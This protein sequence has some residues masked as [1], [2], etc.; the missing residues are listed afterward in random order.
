[1]ANE[2]AIIVNASLLLVQNILIAAPTF[3]G[4]Q[5]FLAISIIVLAIAAHLAGPTSDNV[6]DALPYTLFWPVWLATLEKCITAGKRNIEDFYWRVDR[7]AREGT[8]MLAFGPMKFLW[9]AAMMFNA[10]LVRWNLQVKN[11][12]P[13]TRLRKLNFLAAR[14]LQLVK[15]VLV[16]DLVFQLAIR[17]FWTR[18]DGSVHPDSK[19]LTIRNESWG[20]S[21]LNALVFGCGPYFSMNLQYVVAAIFSVSFNL[22]QP[23][24]WPPLYGRITDATTVRAFWGQFWHQTIRRPLT[25]FA[26]CIT[27]WM[28]FERSTDLTFY[29][30]IWAAF[31]ISGI[32]HAQ[33]L[34]LLPRAFNITLYEA[35][36]GMFYFF[37]WQALAITVEDLIQRAWQKTGH[38]FE[39]LGRM[40][41]V[42]GYMWV[43]CSLWISLPW[44]AD[45]YIRL[46]ITEEPMLSF[47]V[48][49]P[50]VRIRPT[51]QAA[52]DHPA[53][54]S[55]H[56]GHFEFI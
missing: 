12:P 3:P 35:T 16:T 15:L 30:H 44:A 2:A 27:D 17:L 4:R 13:Q 38:K 49:G 54:G 39:D 7:P 6:Q 55:K 47:T 45:A 21:F 20:R 10:R 22:S 5:K 52:F 34:A 56:W 1:M 42:M 8:D 28:G 48:F 19:Y 25:T 29:V 32:M 50:Y 40:R 18:P 11:V 43:A 46:R 24:D 41:F 53:G 26:H 36:A 14:M 33:S 9:V 37:I 31:I 51:S 23:A